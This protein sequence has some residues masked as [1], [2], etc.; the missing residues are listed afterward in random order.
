MKNIRPKHLFVSLLAVFLLASFTRP[1]KKV[2]SN[3]IANNTLDV[4]N[5][6]LFSDQKSGT[7]LFQQPTFSIT[8]SSAQPPTATDIVNS[9]FVSNVAQV[10][11]AK[12]EPVPNKV[13][14]PI[15][16]LPIEPSPINIPEI[17]SN[18]DSVSKTAQVF[19]TL[20]ERLFNEV[21]AP[22]SPL[23]VKPLPI[24]ISKKLIDFKHILWLNEDNLFKKEYYRYDSTAHNFKKIDNIKTIAG[25]DPVRF[26]LNISKDSVA[27]GEEFELKITAEFLD[28]S[29]HL[30][31]QFEG[32]NGFTLKMLLPD[33]FV[34]TGGTYYDFIQGK[35]TR[36]IPRQEFTI[37]GYFEAKPK[38]S[39][40]VLLRSFTGAT[41]TDV[42][43]KK[44][45]IL[46]P[47][48]RSEI[49]TKKQIVQD[50]SK[51]TLNDLINKDSTQIKNFILDCPEQ[52]PPPQ[53]TSQLYC[54][55]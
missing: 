50:K 20:A 38:L 32:S 10:F 47:I 7:S 14:E 49:V 1:L 25:F 18:K 33:N 44:A 24:S 3:F 51:E 26:R 23:P 48:Y 12:V 43:E 28:V 4:R 46:V 13:I 30:I 45:E 36:Q 29:P 6:K 31:F 53:T 11:D 2:E 34:Q 55:Q 15:T 17:V 39:D 54:R 5:I 9:N 16:S 37:K 8:E 21:I 35:V 52:I 42:Y 40:F 41:I 27:V 19:E 22:I